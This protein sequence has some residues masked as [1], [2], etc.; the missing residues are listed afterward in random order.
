MKNRLLGL[1]FSIIL[2]SCIN[3]NNTR[4]KDTGKIKSSEKV[5]DT[6]TGCFNKYP[7]EE[8][9]DFLRLENNGFYS[10]ELNKILFHKKESYVLNFWSSECNSYYSNIPIILGHG[11]ENP[12][13]DYKLDSDF[14]E[15]FGRTNEL[16][17]VIK[18]YFARVRLNHEYIITKKCKF[19]L[20]NVYYEFHTPKLVTGVNI[21][22]VAWY[23]KFPINKEIKKINMNKID[24]INQGEW[25]NI[26]RIE[27]YDME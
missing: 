7:V 6:T 26:N 15:K 10:F 24:S 2:V 27:K 22:T 14:E 19:I 5:Y 4:T 18:F 23:A 1:V 13:L 20:K 25:N 21:D 17:F 3:D 8:K 16:K 9:V 12:F 11:A